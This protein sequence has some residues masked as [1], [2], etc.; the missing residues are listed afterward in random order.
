[1]GEH[2][3]GLRELHGSLTLVWGSLSLVWT[4][5]FLTCFSMSKNSSNTQ[6]CPK[7]KKTQ[8]CLQFVLSFLLWSDFTDNSIVCENFSH[9]DIKNVHFAKLPIPPPY[10][11]ST[12]ISYCNTE[13]CFHLHNIGKYLCNGNLGIVEATSVGPLATIKVCLVHQVVLAYEEQKDVA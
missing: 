11:A 4:D 10:P 5:I 8:F 3:T 7:I 9:F 1:M 12:L 2:K 13:S 6:F